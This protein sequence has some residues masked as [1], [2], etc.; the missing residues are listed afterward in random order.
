MTWATVPRTGFQWIGGRPRIYR[1]TRHG[2]RYFCPACGTQLALFTTRSPRT[3][4][5]TVASLRHPERFPPNRHIWTKHK[6]AWLKLEDGLPQEAGEDLSIGQP[7][8][9]PRLCEKP[10]T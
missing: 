9:A 2:R 3:I 8:P 6:L 1:S 10:E 7:P 4:D 5:V